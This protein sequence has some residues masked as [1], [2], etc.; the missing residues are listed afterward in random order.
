MTFCRDRVGNQIF[1]AALDLDVH[2]VAHRNPEKL[3]T[4][5]AAPFF[6]G[7]FAGLPARFDT[8][9]RELCTGRLLHAL[10]LLI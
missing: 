8:A 7:R 6:A 1:L 9:V 5:M 2:L 3:A 4:T 10:L